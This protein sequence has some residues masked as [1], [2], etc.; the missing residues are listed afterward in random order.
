[1]GHP[2]AI[3]YLSVFN[4]F[5]I[6]ADTLELMPGSLASL[7]KAYDSDQKKQE[8][9]DAAHILY[10]KFKTDKEYAERVL[11]Y[12]KQD[13]RALKSLYHKFFKTMAEV[14]NEKLKIQIEGDDIKPTI[15]ST[16]LHL[17]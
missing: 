1:M 7:C 5:I 9:F 3:K 15:S 14:F 4:N 11:E 12:C 10:E 2:T 8:G 16:A 13:V 17:W 6:F